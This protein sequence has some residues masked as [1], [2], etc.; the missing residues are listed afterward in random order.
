MTSNLAKVADHVVEANKVFLQIHRTGYLFIFFFLP[1]TA[2][3]SGGKS[4]FLSESDR[5]SAGEGKKIASFV[6]IDRMPVNFK[7]I[8]SMLSSKAVWD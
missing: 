8:P 5:K 2:F 4:H 7:G 1:K 6:M 3:C